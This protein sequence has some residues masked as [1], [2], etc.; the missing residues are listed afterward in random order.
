MMGTQ[1]GLLAQVSAAHLVSHFHIMTIPALLPLLPTAMGVSFVDLGIALAV[2]N[3]V[4]ALVQAPLGYAVDRLGARRLLLAGL[5]LG[6]VSFALVSIHPT[7]ETLV[8]AMALAG[9]ANGVYHPSDYSL[10]S[11]NIPPD[12]IGR[13]FSIHTFAG[14]LG[15]ALA[16]LILVGVGTALGSRWALAASSALGLATLAAI[17]VSGWRTPPLQSAPDR[18]DGKSRRSRPP[19]VVTLT[20]LILTAFFLLLNLSTGAIEK[21]SVSALVQGFDVSLPTA[22]LA[23][24]AFLFASAFGVLAGGVLADRTVR[25]GVV[26]AVAFMLAAALVVLVILV[27]LPKPL[28]ILTMGAVGFLTGSIA[29]S[30]D[31][32]VRASAPAGSEGRVFG[33][34]ST[35]FNIGGVIG[36]VLFGYFLDNGFAGGVLWASVGFMIATS[37]I[38][39][40]QEW[41][42][43]FDRTL[44]KRNTA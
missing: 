17:G 5:T 29:P 3:I 41:R 7:F 42:V 16:P 15:S 43:S 1:R 9:M 27:P 30:R 8:G 40:L 34:V 4:T 20:M 44:S 35:G 28:L 24:T 32:L 18:S 38:V 39:V 36:P 11:Q 25:H 19:S 37:L 26:A 33:I 13:A 6:S 21:F 12:R 31:M 22:N 23:L 10:L 2:F 14:F